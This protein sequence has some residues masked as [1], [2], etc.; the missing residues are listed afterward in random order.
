[1]DGKNTFHCTQMMLWQTGPANVRP[2]M[3]IKQFNRAK[4]ITST[5][6]S[7]FHKLD[8][9]LLPV[10]KRPQ[11]VANFP[12]GLELDNW[13]HESSD[14][15]ESKIKKFVLDNSSYGPAISTGGASL[16]SI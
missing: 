11:P 16:G 6:L 9:A 8:H 4:T 5:N 13:F 2:L 12:P 14:Q 15:L 3:D 1:M 10:G 7:E